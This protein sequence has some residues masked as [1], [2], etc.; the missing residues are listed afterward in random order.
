MEL[1]GFNKIFAFILKAAAVVLIVF[2]FITVFSPQDNFDS[3]GTKETLAKQSIVPEPDKKEAPEKPKPH[4]KSNQKLIALTFDDGPYQGVT[5]QILDTLEKN[6]VKATFF[7]I[8]R[9]VEE[10]ADLLKRAKKLGCEIGNHTWEHRPLTKLSEN[11]MKTTLKRTHDAVKDYVGYD[12]KMVRPTYGRMDKKV[13]DA[14]NG[15]LIYWCVD[16]EDWKGK[17]SEEIEHMI[18]GKVKDGDIVLMHDIYPET[19]KALTKI[20]PYLKKKGFKIVTI[21]EMM[22]RK[23]IHMEKGKVYYSAR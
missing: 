17:K 9:Q 3:T 13:E 7:T 20:V 1:R 18:Y 22:E 11:E 8:G 6:K 12:I 4:K 15:P 2:I 10:D 5:D 14:V 23:G 21:S 19:A 16:T